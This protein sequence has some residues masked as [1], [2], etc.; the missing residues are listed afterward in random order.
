MG[1]SSKYGK[2]AI[3]KAQ[4]AWNE[5]AWKSTTH[6]F[7]RPPKTLND[8]NFRPTS[9]FSETVK[10]D[11]RSSGFATNH[12][13]LDGTGWKPERILNGDN[14]RTEYRDRFNPRK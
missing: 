1:S 14:N 7:F 5:G 3:L 9:K 6:D 4:P 11:T 10:H 13:Y 12:A 2:T 8:P